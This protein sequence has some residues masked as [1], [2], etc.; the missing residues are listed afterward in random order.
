MVAKPN[1]KERLTKEEIYR[2]LKDRIARWWMPNDVVFLN[3]IPKTSV[4]KLSKRTL[5]E[6]HEQGKLG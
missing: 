6:W 4:G 5:R 2:Y 3:E 1:A